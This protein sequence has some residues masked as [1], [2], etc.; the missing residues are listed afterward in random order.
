[1]IKYCIDYIFVRH[2]Y[3]KRRT[4]TKNQCEKPPR[5]ASQHPDTLIAKILH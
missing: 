1:M 2:F 3:Q 4:I 5:T